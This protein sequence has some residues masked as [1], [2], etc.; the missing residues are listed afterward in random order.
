ML[1]HFNSVGYKQHDLWFL[2][3]SRIVDDSSNSQL[4]NT[5]V[6]TFSTFVDYSCVEKGYGIDVILY[7]ALKQSGCK[8]DPRTERIKYSTL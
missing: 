4:K 3:G 7:N 8:L 1:V 6:Y 5:F 2:A